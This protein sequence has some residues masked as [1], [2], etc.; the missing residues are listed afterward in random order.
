MSPVL[1][2]VFE[3]LIVPHRSLTRTGVRIV[4]CV[5][6]V[7]IMAIAVRFGSL[8]AWP[9][10]AFSLLEIPLVVVLL[11]LNGRHARASELI[12]LDADDLTVIRIDPGGRRKQVSLPAAWLRVDLDA[13]RGVSHV[14]LSSH[15]R[16]CEVGGFLHESA[17]GS[18]FEALRDALHRSRNPRFENPQLHDP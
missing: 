4:I 18:L 11:A 12:M 9:V 15:G 7:P 8:G 5:L 6:M 17:K 16:R 13:E 2:P 10:A 1:V 3:A 14:V